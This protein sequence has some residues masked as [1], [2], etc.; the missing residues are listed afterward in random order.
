MSSVVPSSETEN[1]IHSL[2]MEL[3]INIS[4]KV[5]FQKITGIKLENV[6]PSQYFLKKFFWGKKS[7]DKYKFYNNTNILKVNDA[8]QILFDNNYLTFSTH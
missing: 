6:G 3:G 1:I 5:G 8:S 7:F 2:N 4:G